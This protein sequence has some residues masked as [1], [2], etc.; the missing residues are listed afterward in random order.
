M[1]EQVSPQI[2][3]L[4]DWS[5]DSRLSALAQCFALAFQRT[6]LKQIETQI[7][8]ELV[9]HQHYVVAVSGSVVYGFVS[10]RTWFEPRHRLAELVHIG[11]LPDHV[12]PGLAK[13]LVTHMEE[14]VH[15]HYRQLGYSGVRKM[16]LLT[17]MENL[18]ARGFYKRCG[19]QAVVDQQGI[20]VPLFEFTREGV[21]EIVMIKDWPEH[22]LIV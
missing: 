4:A 12:I 18:M 2:I 17:H 19:Y 7:N 22:R 1:N 10:W 3:S 21:D 11:V 5:E 16:F 14:Q 13:Q 9:E 8:W 6:D 15:A 20:P